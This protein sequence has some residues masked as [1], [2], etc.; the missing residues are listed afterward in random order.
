MPIIEKHR[1]G[2]FCWIEL[3]TSDQNAAKKFYSDLFGW[4][5]SDMP[6][7]PNEFYTMFKLE[8]R[9]TGAAYTLRPDQKANGV[10]PH[11]GLYIAVDNADVAAKRVAELGGKALAPP[12]DVFD[13][14][15]MAVIQDPAGAHFCLWQSNKNTGTGISA[16][17]GTLCW[18]DHSSAD[19][20]RA[21]AF[22]TKLF[23]W[24]IM[25][26][27]E[28]PEHNYWHIKNGE[29]F[30]GGFPPPAHRDPHMPSHWLS[31]LTAKDCDATVAKAKSLGAKLYF[32]PMDIEKNGRFAV[33]AD[34][35]GAVFAIFTGTTQS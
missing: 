22:Y 10:P 2:E 6:M 15:R 28:A 14:G 30:I 31:Y 7:G 13:A 3:A 35:Q 34:P 26:E 29:D 16:N 5:I 19:R 27:D 1:A 21:A 9:D 12:F 32:G 33:L 11:W 25:K 23:G 18:A 20:E 4:T 17:H 24:T 8:G